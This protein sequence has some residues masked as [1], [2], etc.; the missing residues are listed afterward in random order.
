MVKW[1]EVKEVLAHNR[2]HVALMAYTAV[3]VIVTDFL[4]GVL[5]AIV[6]YAVLRR[7][8]D[9]PPATHP[10]HTPTAEAALLAVALAKPALGELLLGPAGGARPAFAARGTVTP[11]AGI[12]VFVSVAGHEGSR[13]VC[14]YKW[15]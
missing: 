2:F 1:G 9:Q 4:T 3:M 10:A 8:F 14:R 12:V 7:F 13:F 5:G 15:Q 11:A 6:L